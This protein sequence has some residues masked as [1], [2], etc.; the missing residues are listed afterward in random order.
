MLY[1]C[2]KDAYPELT[3]D[4]VITECHSILVGKI[5]EEEREK[6]IKIL[7]RIFIT[8]KKYRLM[9]CIDERT[10]PYEVEGTFPIWHFALENMDISMNYGVYA[11]G[12]LL[13][14]SSCIMYYVYEG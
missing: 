2:P 7:G 4:L 10:V 9:A 12:G 14:E 6:T 3:D 8:D 11:N 1:R 13:V 5:T